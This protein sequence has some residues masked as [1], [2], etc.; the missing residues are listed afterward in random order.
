MTVWE[1][2]QSGLRQSEHKPVVAQGVFRFKRLA[3]M[4]EATFFT[5]ETASSNEGDT[6]FMPAR[7]TTC[8][9]P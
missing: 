4:G 1:Q 8:S 2:M 6:L 9:G 7:I 5:R 3:F